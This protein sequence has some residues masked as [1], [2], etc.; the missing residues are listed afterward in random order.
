ML[1]GPAKLRHSRFEIKTLKAKLSHYH[2]LRHSC[3]SVLIKRGVAIT[4]LQHHLGH[5]N[6]AIAADQPH[7]FGDSSDSS[8]ADKLA[9][10]MAEHMGSAG[11]SE[12]SGHSV[13]T[14]TTQVAALA[15]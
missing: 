12:E 7:R 10:V 13:G 14:Q 11:E 5:A 4:D 1:F 15:S 8:V 6:P 9:Q 2:S 3:A